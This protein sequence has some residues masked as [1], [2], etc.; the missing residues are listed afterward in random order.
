MENI[1][2]DYATFMHFT[3]E[4]LQNSDIDMA[5]PQIN[6]ND[7]SPSKAE[8]G[9]PISPSYEDSKE[10]WSDKEELL[11]LLSHKKYKNKWNDV[12]QALNGRSN[13]S[14][15]NRFYSIFRKI[16]NKIKK[17]DCSYGTR[18]ARAEGV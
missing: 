5:S 13:N 8:L 9:D 18:F 7:M 2:S 10:P 17:S 4:K 1:K 6:S 14:I 3:P 11:M 12:A 16:K 15:K